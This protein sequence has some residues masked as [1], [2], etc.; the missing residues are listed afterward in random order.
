MDGFQSSAADISHSHIIIDIASWHSKNESI[1]GSRHSN[2]WT[3]NMVYIINKSLFQQEWSG[4]L[5]ASPTYCQATREIGKYVF[6]FSYPLTILSNTSPL[7]TRGTTFFTRYSPLS[8]IGSCIKDYGRYR[9]LRDT[10]DCC[11]QSHICYTWS[12]STKRRICSE[13]AQTS[14]SVTCNTRRKSKCCIYAFAMY[15]H[16]VRCTTDKLSHSKTC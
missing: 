14:T 7:T 3:S 9:V 1:E 4:Y 11:F 13:C 15:I 10:F 8:T 2:V 5:V 12:L 16:Y 6:S